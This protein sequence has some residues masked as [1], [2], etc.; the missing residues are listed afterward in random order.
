MKRS[1]NETIKATLDDWSETLGIP[2]SAPVEDPTDLR[3]KDWKRALKE[4]QN[5]IGNKNL[6]VL[7]AGVAYFATLSFFPMMV[8]LVSIGTLFIKPDQVESLVSAANTYLPNDIAG[9]VTAQM[10]T[11]IDKPSVS[12]WAAIIAIAIALWGI[13]GAVENLIKAL[14]VNY[15]VEESRNFFAM[16]LTSI[17][18]TA[19]VVLVLLIIIPMI[20][21][22]EAWLSGWGVPY[23]LATTASVLRWLL[24]VAIIMASLAVLYRYGPNRPNVKWQWVSWGAIIATLLWMLATGAFFVYA[25][26]FANFSDS[27]SLFA[28]IIVLMT[29]FNLSAMTFLIGAEINHNLEQKKTVRKKKLFG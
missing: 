19:G 1:I 24:L 10:N 27:Y 9:L 8:A 25:K 12:L 11:L 18:L 28:G 23:R 26:Y 3:W 7:A 21:I 14:N 5:A 20:G 4:T 2:K 13:S 29:W 17:G 22:S 16:K 6:S 15:D